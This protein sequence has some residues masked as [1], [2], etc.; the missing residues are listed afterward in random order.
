MVPIRCIQRANTEQ[1][2][3]LRIYEW[4]Y[5]WGDHTQRT[6]ELI[7]IVCAGAHFHSTHYNQFSI[8]ESRI[9]DFTW[10]TGHTRPYSSVLSGKKLLNLHVLRL[11]PILRRRTQV[12]LAKDCKTHKNDLGEC[13]KQEHWFSCDRWCVFFYLWI[14]SPLIR[15][16][17]V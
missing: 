6:K 1:P 17:T 4:I 13:K 16:D 14:E 12:H 15:I 7:R 9:N 2:R 11:Q 10:R 5:Q 8:L 3:K